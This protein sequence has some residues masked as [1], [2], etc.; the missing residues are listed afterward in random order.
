[1]IKFDLPTF[2]T[3]Q[4]GHQLALSV[5]EKW[6]TNTEVA[7]QLD[8]SPLTLSRLTGTVTLKVRK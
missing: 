8:I 4:F 3:P 5:K 7:Q 2:P 6:F 1:V